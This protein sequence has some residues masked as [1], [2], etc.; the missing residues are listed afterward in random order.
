MALVLWLAFKYCYYYHYYLHQCTKFG[1]KITQR[2]QVVR[3]KIF[4]S[5]CTL[6]LFVVVFKLVVISDEHL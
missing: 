2:R 1:G 5:F 4:V 3:T 6:T